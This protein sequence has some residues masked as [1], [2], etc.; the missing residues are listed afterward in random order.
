M[1]AEHATR[2]RRSRCRSRGTHVD[3][4]ALARRRRGRAVL[5]ARASARPRLRAERRQ[6][7]RGRGDLPAAR[8]AAAGDRAGGRA[9]RAAL[10][11]RDRR[12]PATARSARWARAA[13][14]AR[15]P[16]DAARD[17]RLEPRPAR[18]RRAGLLRA[19]RRVRRRRHGGGGGD[20][21]RRRPR[22]ARPARRQE[23]ARAPPRTRT[24]RRGWGCWR[25]CG[26]TPPSAS[27]RLPD[28]EAVRERHFGY[29]LA[30]ARRHGID[31]A[32]DGPDRREHLACLDAEVE[33]FRAALQ[34][35]AER[36]AAERVLEL[37]AAL[38]DYWMRRD[39]YPRPWIGSCRRCAR[40]TPPPIRRC[41]PARWARCAGRSGRS[42]AGTSS[43][44]LLSEAEAIARTLP[45]LA[46]RAEVLY[47]CA[48]VMCVSGRADARRRPP[49][50]RWPAPNAAGDAWMIA[51]AAWARAIAAGSAEELRE[52]VDEAAPLLERVGNAY[53]LA[54]LFTMP[55]VRGV[56]TAAAMATRRVPA[57]SAAAGARARSA[58]HWMACAA[59]SDS[60][61]CWPGDIASP[62]ATRS[63]NS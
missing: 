40:R 56:G 5:R 55:P 51:M 44:A 35:A 42:G 29:F 13:R 1:Q 24:D 7:R 8:R 12:A 46:I 23:P 52:R 59:T 36:D 58:L 41:A 27:R 21:H 47:N 34:W 54:S 17:A 57:T 2:C 60:P 25:P 16:A 39:R 32:L 31:P 3:L 30:L 14:R 28:G 63:A 61:R 62:A 53:Q 45:D 37:S 48:A 33:N 15:P 43:L 38:V 50:R 9:L 22:H 20:D 10:P 11:E 26:R 6:R 18:R 19:L 4:G 49:T